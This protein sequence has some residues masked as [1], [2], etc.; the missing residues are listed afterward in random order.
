MNI[1]FNGKTAIVTGGAS[2]IGKAVAE[3]F[4]RA[5]GTVIVS[6]L[7]IGPAEQVAAAINAAGGKAH[8]FAGDVSRA[9]DAEAV[10]RFA[11]EKTGKLSCLV[12]NAGIA[13]EAA[14]TGEYPVENWNTVVGVNLT[15]V[16]LG[17][18]FAIPAM[19]RAG[20]GAIVNVASILGT[21]GFATAPA[22]VAAKHGVVGL[23]KTAALEHAADNIR[24]NSVGPG[25]IQTPLVEES[26]DADALA[27][28]RTQH[29]LGRLGAPGEVSGLVLFLLS[30][31]ASFITGSYHLVDG[32]YTAQ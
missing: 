24:I 20:G 5:G 10:V 14:V 3:G 1:D 2:G 8:A 27:F 31:Q 6:D 18:R 13:G 7:K 30:D 11:E 25:F 9:Q 22:Y 32:G 12:N 21:V 28:L 26:L 4:A 15:G 23:T 19:K 17:M 16:F 29:A